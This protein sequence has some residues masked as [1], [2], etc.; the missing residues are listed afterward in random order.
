MRSTS[1][2]K[3]RFATEEDIP[4]ILTLIKGIAEYEK[5]LHEVTATEE[6][7]HDSLFVKKAAEV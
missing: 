4:S 6:I 2:M 5:L 3:I 7:L 1:D